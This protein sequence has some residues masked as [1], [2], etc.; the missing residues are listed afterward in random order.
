MITYQ[1]A[2]KTFEGETME[3]TP[4]GKKRICIPVMTNFVGA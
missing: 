4:T 3:V 2:L 1:K